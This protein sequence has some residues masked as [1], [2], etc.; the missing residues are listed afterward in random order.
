MP[1]STLEQRVHTLI[2]ERMDPYEI[3]SEYRFKGLSGKRRWRFDFAVPVLKIAVEC[4]GSQWGSLVK[5]HRCGALV[6]KRYGDKLVPVREAGGRHTRGVGFAGD[7]EKYTEAAAEGW[8]IARVT[9]AMLRK[10]EQRE[11]FLD[12]LRNMRAQRAWMVLGNAGV[13][14]P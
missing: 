5:C 6:M 12:I 11:W 9:S 14:V 4:E 1:K 10:P 13:N 2:A 8:F 3:V 7:I